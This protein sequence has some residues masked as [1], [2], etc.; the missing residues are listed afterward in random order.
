MV[1]SR[2]RLVMGKPAEEVRF[3]GVTGASG[4]QERSQVNLGQ[5]QNR[6]LVV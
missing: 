5:Q 3:S 2:Q 6:Q 4:R 1:R